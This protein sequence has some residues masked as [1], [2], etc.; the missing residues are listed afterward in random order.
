M[1]DFCDVKVIFSY[2]SF[3][4]S[5]FLRSVTSMVNTTASALQGS[6]SAATVR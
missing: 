3:V 5:G 6:Q 2:I 4:S 1:I